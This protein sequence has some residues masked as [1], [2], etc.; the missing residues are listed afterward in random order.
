MVL[1]G[2]LFTEIT[3][4]EK[5]LESMTQNNK[6]IEEHPV[7]Q[8]LEGSFDF[9]YN[10]YDDYD[11]LRSKLVEFIPEF[12]MKLKLNTA[13]GYFEFSANIDSV[14][15]TAWYTLARM[16]SENPALENRGN[17]ESRP[18][19]IMI[20]CRNCGKFIIRKINRQ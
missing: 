20:F 15:N 1:E 6:Y 9:N 16:I 19:G 11:E 7:K 2:V 4:T 5:L 3:N 10:P 12:N 13:T 18:E 8:P 17:E 14:C